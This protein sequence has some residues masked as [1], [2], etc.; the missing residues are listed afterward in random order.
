MS[1]LYS[2]N[3]HGSSGNSSNSSFKKIFK[4]TKSFEKGAYSVMYAMT[5][6]NTF[7]KILT[8]FSTI[9]EFIQ[10]VSFGFKAIFPWGGET[11]YWLTR[12]IAPFSHPSALFKYQAYTILF[13]IVVSLM[14]LGFLN[15]F[16][17][18]YKFYQGKIANI[19]FIRTLRWFVSFT[20]S[21]LYIPIIS[22]FLISLYCERD[23]IG[24]SVLA[25]F[26]DQDEKIQCFGSTNSPLAAISIV[27]IIAFS[28]I[29]FLTSLTYYEFDTTV[30]ARFA[31][32]HAR[33]DV[34]ILLVK[35]IFSFFFTLLY[36]YPWVLSITFFIGMIWLTFGSIFFLPFNNQ[37]LNQVKTGLYTSVLWV[38]ILTMATLASNNTKSPTTAYLALVG[39]IPAFALGYF[40]NYFYY[41]WL[42]IKLDEFFEA[43]GGM[44]RSR[45]RSDFASKEKDAIELTQST[46]QLTENRVKFAENQ[47]GSKKELSF[48]FFESRYVFSHIVEIM[49]R[50][51]LA[52]RE[53]DQDSIDRANLFYQCG[54]QYFPRSTLVWMAYSNFL[55]S[56]RKDRHVG[57]ASLEKLRS[58]NP[59]MIDIRFFIFQRDRDREQMMDSELRGPNASKIEDFVSYMEFKKLYSGA[60][61]SHT[62]CLEYIRRFWRHLVHETV[63]LSR[64]SSLSGKIANSERSA[65]EQYERLLSLNPS[66]VRVLRDYS[67]FL[68]E[69]VKDRH[70]SARLSKRADQIEESMSKSLSME[71]EGGLG[72]ITIDSDHE[73]KLEKLEKES[74]DRPNSSSKDEDTSDTSG[75]S[76]RAA[77]RYAEYQQSNSITKLAW[78]IFVTALLSLIFLIA[79]FVVLR[80]QTLSQKYAFQGIVSLGEA[81]A[82]SVEIAG[83]AKQMKGFTYTNDVQ[84]FNDMQLVAV[85]SLNILENI[86]HAIYWGETQPYSFVGDDMYDLMSQNGYHM[87]DIGSK[88][89]KYSDFNKTRPITPTAETLY[90]L[91]N[92][93]SGNF[94]VYI[95][96]AANW[97]D[98]EYNFWKAGNLFVDYGLVFAVLL[99][100]AVLLFRP[101]VSRITN[102]TLRTMMLFTLAPRDMVKKLSAKRPKFLNNI[103]SSSDRD[104]EFYES[105][106]EEPDH[107]E[108]KKSAA[109][110]TAD[111]QVI[112]IEKLQSDENQEKEHLLQDTPIK[113]EKRNVNKKSLRSILIKLH[114]SYIFALFL[115]FGI[116]TMSLFVS[117]TETLKDS[118]AGSDLTLCA[119]RYTDLHMVIYYSFDYVTMK[120]EWFAGLLLK[121]VDD[122]QMKHQQLESLSSTRTLMEG[123]YGCYM[124]NKT[125]C[126]ASNDTYYGDVSPGLD[127]TIEQFIQNALEIGHT[128]NTS[129]LSTNMEPL[130]WINSVGNNEVHDGMARATFLFF[131]EWQ[132]IQAKAVNSI[133]I[134]FVVGMVAIVV[135][136]VVLFRPFIRRLRVQHTH[137]LGLI[138]LMPKDIQS[139]QV[140]DKLL[141]D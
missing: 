32:P 115:L 111:D 112:D 79:S 114:Y 104:L 7:P 44:N 138:R 58:L 54:L 96:S 18:G 11:G 12:I 131:D 29:A 102:E 16:Y 48:P 116:I 69:V 62:Q 133:T 87:Y 127:W 100:I 139:L 47:L 106:G 128:T 85:R 3:S 65:T 34:T 137:T 99:L 108:K 1:S 2:R 55:I 37:H 72:A 125:L 105:G 98:M 30:T 64:L 82:I 117:F 122:L 86:H 66:S 73:E 124:I 107:K 141:E 129:L 101:V 22:L 21:V 113:M 71:H 20:V 28:L 35:T 14:L 78:L 135:I 19:H 130:A 140:D 91:Y 38:S 126:R 9:I 53:T 23:Q 10:L 15:M 25:K 90:N 57:Y 81:A 63:D 136:Y 75:S 92:S 45:S 61:R 88:A 97:T 4:F 94:T 39:V 43:N 80:N 40:A 93:P 120:D 83:F 109:A 31:K 132:D 52:D 46:A 60:R 49:A 42:N 77:R 26:M 110:G 103:D 84:A 121:Y 51:L 89:F 17:V 41:R 70:M 119:Q 5:K 8:I 134:A 56:V 33:F 95:P 74:I 36:K 76:H 13:W 67:Q 24:Q 68:D 118:N 50:R 6:N 27:L 59:K 123:G